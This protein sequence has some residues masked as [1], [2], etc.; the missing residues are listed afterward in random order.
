MEVFIETLRTQAASWSPQG[1]EIRRQFHRH[2]EL[3]FQETETAA[4]IR[5]ILDQE[6]IRYQSD[7]G[8]HGIV[9]QLSSEDPDS[10]V[11]AVRADMD[12]LPI[13]ETN[14]VDYSSANPGVMHACGHDVHMT[15]LIGALILLN[16]N[17]DQW[18]GTIKFIF[19][20]A[21]EKL[22]GGASILIREGVLENPKPELILG[23]HVHPGMAVGTIGFGSGAFMASCDE[24]YLTIKGRGGHAAQPHT[25]IDPVYVSAQVIV[26]LQ[27]LIS[28]EKPAGLPAVL[29]IGTIHTTGG[30]TNVIPDEVKLSGTFRT[31]DESFR[32]KAHQRIREIINGICA[33]YQATADIDIQIG[34]PCLINEPQAS[35]RVRTLAKAFLGESS[36]EEMEPRLTSEDF[37][38]YSQKIPAVFFRLGVGDVPG[39]HTARFDVDERAISVGASMMAYLA[40]RV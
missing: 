9:G 7:I 24:L 19:Q 6:G 39:V 1:I 31:L 40:A 34:Y 32:T 10:R 17:K 23:L 27:A 4:R 33:S 5:A 13:Q 15:C 16:R 21:E 11:I 22:P 38:Y 18:K 36:V 35:M 37:A 12:A 29:S 20:P 30:A 2:P 14:A 28:R 3:S 8:G 26:A 25:V